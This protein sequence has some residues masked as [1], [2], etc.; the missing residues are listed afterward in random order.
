[1][2]GRS[3]IS[4]CW[5]TRKI[6]LAW[7]VSGLLLGTTACGSAD[8]SPTPG[9]QT[10]IFTP[11]TVLPIDSAQTS[12]PAP[13]STDTPKATP[14]TTS[15]VPAP[16]TPTPSNPASLGFSTLGHP[17]EVYSYGSG[18]I[19]VI[20]IGGI[21]GGYEWNTILLAYELIDHFDANPDS[22][23]PQLTVHIIPSANPDGLVRVIGHAG[24]FSAQ[25]VLGDTFEGRFNG[26]GVDLN[27]NWDCDWSP[28]AVWR[29]I[30][31]DPGTQPFSEVETMLLR[32]FILETQPA[33][34][35]FWHSAYPAVFP[36]GCEGVH[37]QSLQLSKIYAD[38]AGYPA[39]ETF[40][41]YAVTGDSTNWLAMQNIPSIEVELTNHQDTEFDKNLKGVLSMLDFLANQP[42]QP[43]GM[44]Q[45]AQ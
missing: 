21:H 18:P 10:E 43:P 25:E 38:S 2:A 19:P 16:A 26:N 3:T 44:T 23:P 24:R 29:D 33:G 1:M 20:L 28:D 45:P 35:V 41:S 34:V 7:L 32:D 12:T 42:V 9:P 8:V 22:L 6:L 4:C 37:E 5:G 39:L 13:V 31:L 14:T 40:T 27:R 11:H 36:G 17:I 15:T 30:K